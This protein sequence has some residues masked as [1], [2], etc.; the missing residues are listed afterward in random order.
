MQQT[1]NQ[2]VRF[3]PPHTNGR[4]VSKKQ[5][6]RNAKGGVHESCAPSFRIYTET[7]NSR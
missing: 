4:E 1:R 2:I 6:I 7:Q 3:T 5:H